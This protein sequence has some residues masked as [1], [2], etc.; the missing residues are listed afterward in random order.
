MKRYASLVG[1]VVLLA[2]GA[3]LAVSTEGTA[4]SATD[5]RRPAWVG[6]S[7]SLGNSYNTTALYK[8]TNLNWRP[9]YRLHLGLRPVWRVNETLS[10][11]GRWGFSGAFYESGRLDAPASLSDVNS[12]KGQDASHQLFSSSD[13]TL[14]AT[15]SNLYRVPVVELDLSTSAELTLPTSD[16]SWTANPMYLGMAWEAEASRSFN[17]L[18]GLSVAYS[19]GVHKTFYESYA[20]SRASSISASAGRN[21]FG[22]SDDEATGLSRCLLHNG[23]RSPSMGLDH[24]VQLSFQIL[25]WLAVKGALGASY[26]FLPDLSGDVAATEVSFSPQEGSRVRY[27]MAET[28]GVSVGG[29]R[30]LPWLSAELGVRGV[31]GTLG[32]D[33][34]YLHP[35]DGDYANYLRVYLNL[36]VKVGRLVDVLLN[37][38]DAA[39][40]QTPLHAGASV[41]G[42]HP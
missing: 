19:F 6:S 42:R 5:A 16:Y 25:D 35:F 36:N 41:T 3:A 33:G 23:V 1:L 27:S 12:A 22:F 30:A 39:V 10:F 4:L 15:A 2:S 38:S 17:V 18:Q 21:C 9:D 11:S 7:V 13:L 31:H 26:G 14:R 40:V 8:G 34:Q 37:Q 29:F 24:G 28:L 32:L 20:G